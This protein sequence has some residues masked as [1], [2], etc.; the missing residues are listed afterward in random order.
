[1]S[2]LSEC[3]ALLQEATASGDAPSA[4]ET[5]A[6]PDDAVEAVGGATANGQADTK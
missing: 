5:E 1:M 2:L 3:P 4:Q 6:K